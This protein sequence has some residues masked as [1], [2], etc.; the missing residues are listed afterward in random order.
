MKLPS[1]GMGAAGIGNLYAPVSEADARGAVATAWDAGI[2]Y[3]D[4]APH[5][6]FGLSERRLG[7]ALAQV[8]PKQSAIVSTKVGRLLVPTRSDARERHGFVDAEPFEPVFDYRRDA[9]LRSHETS[10]DRLRRDR[11]NILLAH[12]LGTLT[13]GGEADRHMRDFLDGGYRAMA[14]LKASGA[15]DLIGIGVNETSVCEELIE[16]VELDVILLAGRYTLLDQRAADRVLPLCAEKGI[17]FIA[18]APYNSGILAQPTREATSPHYD[19]MAPPPALLER[20]AEIERVCQRHGV[21]LPAAALA[22]PLQHPAVTCVLTGLA[23][24]A[25]VRAHAER[26]QISIPEDMW[27]ELNARG[28]VTM[29]ERKAAA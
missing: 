20:S 17:S 28:L 25:E 4:T 24:E 6:G 13:H 10:L 23:S 14:D 15:V 16:R 27:I 11:M 2:R 21:P 26:L 29:P 5:Y 12:D 3:Y 8:D 19:Y 7:D 22:F 9:I 18:G 1:H